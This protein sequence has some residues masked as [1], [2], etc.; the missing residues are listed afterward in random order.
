MLVADVL[1]TT[2]AASPEVGTFGCNALRRRIDHFDQFRF[3][4]LF[5]LADDF[6]RNA[7]T[8]DRKRNEDGLAFIARDPLAAK[9]DIFDGKLQHSLAHEHST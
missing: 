2:A 3:G 6:R 9:S 5:F 4:E 8:V 7:L 1:V